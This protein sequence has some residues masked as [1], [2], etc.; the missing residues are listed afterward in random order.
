[1]P[2]EGR[3]K[4]QSAYA[5]DLLGTEMT[6]REREVE[7]FFTAIFEG[8]PGGEPLVGGVHPLNRFKV[9]L[10][11]RNGKRCSDRVGA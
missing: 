9:R 7:I 1:M 2:G 11:L 5:E 10:P 8:A 4:G 3:K 6:N